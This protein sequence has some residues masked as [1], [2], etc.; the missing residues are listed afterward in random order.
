VDRNGT[1]V[2]FMLDCL[3]PDF[4]ALHTAFRSSVFSME[5]L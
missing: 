5:N 4:Q 3:A 1:E 2:S